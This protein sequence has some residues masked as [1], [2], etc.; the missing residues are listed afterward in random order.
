M[1]DGN[2]V[3][4]G[5]DLDAAPATASVQKLGAAAEQ[6]AQSADKLAAAG[7]RVA[8][9]SDAAG[10]RAARQ[11]Q[12]IAQLNA[13][14]NAV[15]AAKATAAATGLSNSYTTLIARMDALV[16]AA[17]AVDLKNK[18]VATNLVTQ[19]AGVRALATDTATLAQV[20][21]RYQKVLDTLNT[22]TRAAA[23]A[24][25]PALAASTRYLSREMGLAQIEALKMDEAI[26]RGSKGHEEHVHGLGRITT[27]LGSLVGHAVGVPPVI[28][29]IAEVLGEFAVG[30]TI[31][32]AVTAGLAVIA[33]AW[34]YLAAGAHEARKAAEEYA[35]S[36]AGL[37]ARS[38]ATEDVRA[39]L[40]TTP[41]ASQITRI[42]STKE[43]DEGLKALQGLN[44]ELRS[45][46]HAYSAFIE[47]LS[48]RLHQLTTR[49]EEL[50]AGVADGRI[51]SEQFAHALHEVERNFP[52]YGP[53]IA[54]TA[55]LAAMYTALT[56]EL[57][58]LVAEQKNATAE[59]TALASAFGTDGL[60]EARKKLAESRSRVG[61]LASGGTTGL[62]VRDAQLE[63]VERATKSWKE[64]A[65][66]KEG[67]R[68][69]TLAFSTAL[70]QGNPAALEAYRIAQQ[71]IA[72]DHAVTEGKQARAEAERRA[73]E[74]AREAA[75][76][77][78][79][80]AAE[81]QKAADD[82]YN[83][84][85]K[86]KI[87]V[88]GSLEVAK[89]E[90]E[91]M[92]RRVEA[93]RQ[94]EAASRRLADQLE[95]ERVSREFLAKT[96]L[97]DDDAKQRALATLQAEIRARQQ[98]SHT[99]DDEKEARDKAAAAEKK[100]AEDAS[101]LM[102]QRVREIRRVLSST[103]NTFFTDLLT[104]GKNVFQ[105]IWDS[106]KA[107]FFR[108]ISDMLAAKLTEKF[109][110]MLGLGAA[111][112]AKVQDKAGDKMIEAS[113]RQLEAA[114]KMLGIHGATGGDSVPGDGAPEQ[115]VKSTLQK[116][117]G[118]IGKYAPEAIAGFGF[119]Y[120]A[121]QSMSSTSHGAFGNYARGG[122]VGAAGGAVIG[123]EL[124]GPIGAVVGAVAG[125]VGGI[126][127]A[128]KAMRDAAKAADEMRTAVKLST[129]ALRAQVNH[130]DLGAALAQVAADR[131]KRRK[132]IEDAYSGGGASSDTVRMR[133]AALN[134]MNALEDKYVAQLKEEAAAKSRYFTEDLDVRAL[135]A[136]GNTKGAD[137]LAFKHQQDREL[138][139]YR[140]TH[141]IANN[142]A[143]AAQY[144]Y[145]QQ[146]QALEA[147]RRAVDANTQ[148][149][150]TATRNAPSGF[151]LEG[152]IQ[153]HATGASRPAL[154][155]QWTPPDRPNYT[156]NQQGQQN[157]QSQSSQTTTGTVA[158]AP[159]M[160]TFAAGAIV[161]QESATP[162][163]TAE[164]V[165]KVV[166]TAFLAELDQTRGATSGINMTRTQALEAMKP[167][168]T[169]R[170]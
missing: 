128:G 36:N 54:K 129:A 133:I 142:T 55:Q 99:L 56:E 141:D 91:D 167:P 22:R 150:T 121:G 33:T 170:A 81:Q 10:Q 20:Q 147:N 50:R 158:T 75:R 149:L 24:G 122:L 98:L 83:T 43:I 61:A 1:S 123:A 88:L 102:E 104:K 96:T 109:A 85:N 3:E 168:L 78:K 101:R 6:A 66:S 40:G 2:G 45:P 113:K 143:D 84:Q 103:I 131:E 57:R 71:T 49:L 51:T 111:G 132:E 82:Y 108:L 42:G 35:R 19:A 67:A 60:A 93:A 41:S 39:R 68:F 59:S 87:A 13:Q 139:D 76:E 126:I 53:Q 115:A 64:Y 156:Q 136:Q 8:R 169:V 165:K 30:G 62:E 110:G 144:A 157:Q 97:V 95:V 161:V 152:Y 135:R 18:G 137:D 166:A 11:A 34:H 134:E 164:A 23:S 47:N 146:V 28:D 163:L 107:G 119:G 27:S 9:S 14:L 92:G 86:Q 73:K 17:A 48:P 58:K 21:D 153:Q 125:F 90:T 15:D 32:L 138:D 162:Q 148:A 74:A 106:A 160:V 46:D 63:A 7:E 25:L 80:I 117:I 116:V 69:A 130:D 154:P 120:G 89:R 118:T 124:G 105:S 70:A 77:A 37:A 112:A 38:A 140:R 5:F 100:A 79:Q 159:V 16:N 114:N 44:A 155:G 52:E 72:A 31:T 12:D 26:R 151:K 94:G 4:L 127:G 29:R 65:T 145:L